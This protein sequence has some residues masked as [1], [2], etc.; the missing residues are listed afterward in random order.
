M[1]NLD[2]QKNLVST[3]IPF[4]KKNSL[5]GQQFLLDETKY[6]EWIPLVN[7][8]W[9]GAIPVTLFSNSEKQVFLERDIKEVDE[10]LN[11]IKPLLSK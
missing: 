10:L 7:E 9:G 8:E 3:V 5:P 6:N 1:V 11:I 4:L 2:Y